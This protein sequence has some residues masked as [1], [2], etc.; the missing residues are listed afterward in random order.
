MNAAKSDDAQRRLDDPERQHDRERQKRRATPHD[1]QRIEGQVETPCTNSD[2]CGVVLLSWIMSH[3]TS[4][5][6]TTK[7]ATTP[8]S[9]RGVRSDMSCT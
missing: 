5:P 4:G 3:A 7:T 6:T 1:D 9:T 8:T 2:P